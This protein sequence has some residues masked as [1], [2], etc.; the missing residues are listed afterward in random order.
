MCTLLNP[1]LRTVG[2]A[3]PD[4]HAVRNPRADKTATGR[5]HLSHI[6]NQ[7][8]LTHC[9]ATSPLKLLSPRPAGP[10]AWVYTST[11]GGGLVAGDSISLNLKLEAKTKV[12]LSTQSST[13]IYRSHAGA[14]CRQSLSANLGEDSLLIYAPDPL[15]CFA[16]SIYEQKQS[17][18]LRPTSSLFFLDSLTSGRHARG[19]R[20]AFARYANRTYVRID[21]THLLADS[22]L[23]DSADGDLTSPFRMGRFNCLST[24]I[25]LGPLFTRLAQ[26]LLTQISSQT[27]PRHS[28]FIVIASPLAEGAVLRLVSTDLHQITEFLSI[29]RPHF[30]Q[31]LGEDPLT[32]KW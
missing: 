2:S 26:Q 8:V 16:E 27:P 12:F 25:L 19:E 23:L 4:M 14:S 3:L 32:R 7:T 9:Y 21:D 30:Q 17:F 22:L 31:L 6:R 13:K 29:F 1:T 10:S 28:D 5:L 15:I 11:F 18:Q 20:W 24:I